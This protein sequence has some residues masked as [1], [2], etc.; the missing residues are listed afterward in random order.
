[1][2][3]AGGVDALPGVRFVRR[4]LGNAGCARAADS[5]HAHA[6][7]PFIDVYV[8]AGRVAAVSERPDN[9][10]AGC[11]TQRAISRRWIN[12]RTARRA[13]SSPSTSPFFQTA[14]A[15]TYWRPPAP[16]CPTSQ[17]TL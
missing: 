10:R 15:N 5:A 16:R 6:A 3:P 9:W 13:P 2:A 11:L 12:V 4:R 1:M 8:R 7:V 14:L 17:L